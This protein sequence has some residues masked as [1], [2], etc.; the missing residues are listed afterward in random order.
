VFVDAG[1][2]VGASAVADG[3]LAAFEVAEDL[4]PFLVAGGS[5]FFAERC[6][7]RRAMNARWPGRLDNSVEAEMRRLARVQ[8][9][10]IDD[11]ALQP[12]DATE[13]AGSN[14]TTRWFHPRGN[15]TIDRGIAG[16]TPNNSDCDIRQLMAKRFL[17]STN[18]QA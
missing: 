11:F 16:G 8:P 15:M 18:S 12:L 10:L 3:D 4:G 14:A 13:T 2:G 6:A 5:V 1:G 7:R 9:P 17:T